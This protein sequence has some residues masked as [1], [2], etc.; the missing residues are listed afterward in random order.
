MY[1]LSEIVFV[2]GFDVEPSDQHSNFQPEF[3]LAVSVTSEFSATV[4]ASTELVTEPAVV[5]SEAQ[6]RLTYFV[7]S[8]P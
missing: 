8:V 2:Y 4:D 3:G 6:E 7:V 5:F 1:V